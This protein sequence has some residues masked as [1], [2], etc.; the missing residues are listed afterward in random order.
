MHLKKHATWK[1]GREAVHVQL[2]AEQGD[3]AL[4]ALFAAS[5]RRVV[6][7]LVAGTDVRLRDLCSSSGV[8]ITLRAG[9]RE[10]DL[11]HAICT[12]LFHIVDGFGSEAS[13]SVRRLC[14]DRF[15]NYR[16]H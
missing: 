3:D 8:T 15:A 1:D 13:R 7:D 14:R 10:I 12:E 9:E 11:I 4:F 5:M 16:Q 2:V 6:R